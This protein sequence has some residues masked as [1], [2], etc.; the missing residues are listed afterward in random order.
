[1]TD[2]KEIADEARHFINQC[3][4]SDLAYSQ[5]Y[6][7]DD[8]GQNYRMSNVQAAIGLAQMETIRERLALK[9]KAA[10]VYAE[11][12]HGNSLLCVR[13]WVG[14][15]W[16][17]PCFLQG[18]AGAGDM[19]VRCRERGVE[20]KRMYTPLHMLPPYSDCAGRET[21]YPNA[22]RAFERAIQLPSYCSITEA[23][24]VEV[25]RVVTKA[26]E[27]ECLCQRSSA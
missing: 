21:C 2:D 23:E 3:R 11:L 13:P 15:D 1:M 20:I 12:L 9:H 17:T 22:T 7:H 18:E 16:V 25:V 26:Y 4:V 27:E 10:R 14:S 19:V 6:Y 24:Q 5:S 8:E